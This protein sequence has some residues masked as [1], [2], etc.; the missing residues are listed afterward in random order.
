MEDRAG[1]DRRYAI[2]YSKINRELGWMPQESFISAILKT[3]EW[4]L[5]RY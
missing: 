5:E 1:H 3:V 4:Y 2:D